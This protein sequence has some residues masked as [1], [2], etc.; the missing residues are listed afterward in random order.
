M[1]Y[2]NKTIIV[3]FP[4]SVEEP[5]GGA[6][7]CR[8]IV[9][10]LGKLNQNVILV[11]VTENIKSNYDEYS[12]QSIPVYPNRV[13]YLLNGID[14]AR[15]VKKIIEEKEV[16]AVISW[17]HEGAFLPKLLKSKN[18]PF[19]MVAASPSY[20]EWMNRKTKLYAL[21]QLTDEWFRW[22]PLKQADFV[23]VSSDFTRK[24]LNRLFGIK[25]KRMVKIGRGVDDSFRQIEHYYS[26][27]VSNLIF[28]GSLEK[29]KGVFDVVDA[30][31]KV[32]A[33]NEKNWKL[34][35]AGWG[36]EEAVKVAVKERGLEQQICFMGC[37]TPVELAE[38]IKW[39]HLAILPSRAESFGRAIAEAQAA[40]LAVVSYNIGSIPEIVTN[41]ET[42][43][44]VSE[45][46]TDLLADAII[47]AILN[48][49]KTFFM[50]KKGREIVIKKFTWE[51]TVQILL[52]NVEVIKQQSTAQRKSNFN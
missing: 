30:L 20:E 24:E 42:G 40:G 35:I 41:G 6:R 38:E 11:P 2:M 25:P 28:Y 23:F 51:K 12:I 50:G 3:T 46:R 52:E 15:Q 9:R 19:G 47:E 48:P 1:N 39:A 21:K 17:S 26:D 22:R 16:S 43:W 44:L 49:E 5:G 10:V 13:H 18:I 8:K 33:R 37:L 34:K 14:V 32:Y 36:D 31:A 27:K 45:G 29:I 4:S 7:S